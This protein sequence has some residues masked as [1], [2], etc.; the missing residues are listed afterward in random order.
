[1]FHH[2]NL[3]NLSSPPPSPRA[4]RR[5]RPNR[6]QT[7]AHLIKPV[8]TRPFSRLIISG[9]FLVTKLTRFR[10]CEGKYS[11]PH[12]LFISFSIRFRL[13]S[14]VSALRDGDAA[15]LEGIGWPA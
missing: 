11:D 6:A 13:E 3:Q 15:D 2:Q 1:M 4:C 9:H 7:V 10:F 14:K 12:F 8:V 5:Q